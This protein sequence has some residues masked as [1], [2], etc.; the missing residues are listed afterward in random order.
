MQAAQRAR[1]TAT[2]YEER[3]IGQKNY[4]AQ[5]EYNIGEYNT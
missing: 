4:G 5:I 3:M 1:I 2:I